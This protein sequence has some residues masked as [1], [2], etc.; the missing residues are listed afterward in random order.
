MLKLMGKGSVIVD[1]SNDDNGPSSPSMRPPMRIP[2]I[3]RE[4]VV[5]YCVSNIPG[6]IANS[7]SIAYA[8]S[9]IPH[10]RAILN[11][12]VAGACVRD[13][14]PP[15]GPSPPTGATSPHEETSALQGR[16]WVRRRD[17]LGIADRQLDPAP[18]ATVTR[19]DNY[20]PL[21]QV[22]L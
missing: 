19:S 3:L 1:I 18:P 14:F 7:T 4:G 11:H 10:F 20:L 17:I 6:A 12:G 16:P 22:K 21:E 9:V 8:A 15:P 13:G 2:A 5:H